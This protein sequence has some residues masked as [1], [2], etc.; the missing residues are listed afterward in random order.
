[1]YRSLPDSSVHGILQARRLASVAVS[2]SRG[3]S[4]PRD[5]T[6]V[7]CVSC[8][9]GKFFYRLNHLESPKV[10]LTLPEGT[11]WSRVGA[12]AGLGPSKHERTRPPASFPRVSLSHPVRHPASGA[13]SPLLGMSC[14]LSLPAI[15]QGQL[16]VTFIG[17]V[18]GSHCPPPTPKREKLVEL[19]AR[20]VS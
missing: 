20:S 10:P 3:S 9:A 8:I 6:Q 2:S 18:P 19:F 17:T 4:R 11:P 13:L 1:M 14:P 16:N 7:S 15:L 5:Q 12:P